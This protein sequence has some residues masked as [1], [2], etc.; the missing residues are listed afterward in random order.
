MKKLLSVLLAAAAVS[1]TSAAAATEPVKIVQPYTAGGLIDR[2][3]REIQTVLNA[4]TKHNFVIDPRIGAGGR[5]AS[6][7]VAQEKDKKTVLLIQSGPAL[8][9][10]SLDKDS[11]YRVSDFMPVAYIGNAPFVLVA[12][13]DNHINSIEKLLAADS[14]TPVFFSS[15]G[16]KTGTH[17]AGEALKI[18]TNKNLVHVPVQGE[19]AAMVEVL[20]N[21][22]SFAFVS[23]S[24]IV[25][26][27]DKLVV[28]AAAQDS[29]IK[30]LPN[31]P[32]LKELGIRGFDNGP[33]WAAV[34][35]NTTADP[36]LIKEIQTVLTRELAKPEVRAVFEQI[37]VVVAT[38]RM[39]KLGEITKA[40]E[41]RIQQILVQG[42][43][44]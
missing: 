6:A 8:I 35:A 13:R 15:S 22:V 43:I 31:V 30:Q 14:Q 24:T 40:E 7:H 23:A 27:E 38:D 11:K 41:T 12:N 17:L 28:V 16:V 9:T 37:G 42:K 4:N 5:I 2:A 19:K 34:Y 18:A 26:Y 39:L 10:T 25:G 3:G 20:A 1:F 29:R 36:A 21:R 32:T 44:E 33:V